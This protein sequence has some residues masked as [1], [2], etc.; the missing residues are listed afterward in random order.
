MKSSDSIRWMAGGFFRPP[1]MRSTARALFRFH[2]HRA[3]NSGEVSTACR[4]TSSTVFDPRNLGTRSRGKLCCGPRDSRMASSLAAAWSS[5]SNVTQNR[6]RRARPN[7]RFR[8]APKGAWPTSCIPPLSSKNRSK[9]MVSMVGSAP[10]ATRPAARYRT[11]VSE[12]ACSMPHCSSSHRRAASCPPS[13]RRSRTAARRAETSSESSTVRPGASPSQNGTDGGAPCASTTRTTP[14][15]TRRIRH[16]VVPRRNTSPA[17]L[18][19]AQ[20]SLTVPMNT[21]SGSAT[22][23][24]SPSSGM[25][26]PEVRAASRAPRRPRTFPLTRSR[27]R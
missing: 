20:S 18:S 22:T 7:A 17:M 9:M 16:D 23:R 15:S 13:S 26:P 3:A 24:K 14:G 27:C 5:K 6:L 11:M 2:R 4:T 19:M 10:S 25:A 1:R 21:S 12:A 8:R